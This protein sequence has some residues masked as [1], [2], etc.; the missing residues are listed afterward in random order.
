[1]NP[2]LRGK[3]S[4]KHSETE[5]IIFI[6]APRRRWKGRA[7]EARESRCAVTHM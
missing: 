3:G 5:E 2:E 1:M 7:N 6:S 4:E